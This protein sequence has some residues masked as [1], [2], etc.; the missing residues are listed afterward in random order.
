MA[1]LG[2]LWP[3]MAVLR[4]GHSGRLTATGRERTPPLSHIS[5]RDKS[6]KFRPVR[7]AQFGPLCQSQKS[8]LARSLRQINLRYPIDAYVAGC[9]VSFV[10][11][12][13]PP[14]GTRQMT[15]TFQTEAAFK[16]AIVAKATELSA[17]ALAELQAQGGT[18]TEEVARFIATRCWEAASEIV[19]QSQYAEA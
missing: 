6:A 1:V 8:R 5:A 4:E 17:A 3:A 15:I 13:R 16:A 12:D 9:I 11:G 2:A 19:T 14:K 18:L 7:P 10:N